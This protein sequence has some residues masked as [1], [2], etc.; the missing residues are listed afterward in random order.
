MVSNMRASSGKLG[1][2]ADRD[3][4]IVDFFL[5]LAATFVTVRSHIYADHGLHRPA[6]NPADGRP[7]CAVTQRRRG[8]G[9]PEVAGLGAAA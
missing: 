6:S 2:C 4:K 1:C 9:G 7:A 8:H 5:Y 3:S